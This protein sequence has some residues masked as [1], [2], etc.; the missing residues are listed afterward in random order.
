MPSRLMCINDA[1]I[2]D[3]KR[4]CVGT[5][6]S[7]AVVRTTS[8]SMLLHRQRLCYFYS[9]CVMHHACA[10]VCHASLS[11]LFSAGYGLDAGLEG[12]KSCRVLRSQGS[13]SGSRPEAL[14]GL[15]LTGP[16]AFLY[17]VILLISQH[18]PSHAFAALHSK[19]TQSNC[20]ETSNAPAARAQQL[21]SPQ[22]LWHRK[23]PASPQRLLA[24]LAL[25]PPHVLAH[26]ADALA[27]VWLRRPL[28]PDLCC[29]LAHVALVIA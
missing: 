19:S 26:I 16:C 25:L 28:L 3:G 6:A 12:Q 14:L 5:S 15:P 10:C 24:A 4:T 8:S 2:A 21:C 17:Y 23:C 29:K 1:C 18:D 9:T 11:S 13:G 7:A 20:S 22:A 27:L